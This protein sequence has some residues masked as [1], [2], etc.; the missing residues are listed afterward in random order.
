MRKR[1]AQIIAVCGGSGSG[2]STLARKFVG[3]AIVATD[4]FYKSLDK[5]D[6]NPDGSYDF[7]HPSAVDLEAC[8]EA[9]QNLQKGEDVWIP[10][11]DMRS[12]RRM[13]TQMIPAPTNGIVVVEGIFAFHSPLDEISNL[14]IFIDT[15]VDQRMARRIRRDVERGRNTL[16]TIK[17][18]IHVE[19]AYTRYI[20][21]MRLLA[22]LVL[23]GDEIKGSIGI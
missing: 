15:P 23:M 11:Y 8:A 13:G 9:C 5:L 16:E 21:P 3:A 14:R 10:V 22:D 20:E 6:L 1:S 17:H 18:S 7:D 2:K 19:E 4:H 12:S